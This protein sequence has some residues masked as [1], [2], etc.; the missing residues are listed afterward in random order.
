M[1]VGAKYTLPFWQANWWVEVLDFQ[2]DREEYLLYRT[3]T[4]LVGSTSFTLPWIPYIELENP[5]GPYGIGV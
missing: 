3:N 2:P 5:A 4:G 1:E